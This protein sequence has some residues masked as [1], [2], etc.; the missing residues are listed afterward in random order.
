[1]YP[2]IIED[3]SFHYL[4]EN[5]LLQHLF[6]AGPLSSREEY[7]S[8]RAQWNENA[9]K[10]CSY[11]LRHKPELFRNNPVD[12][13]HQPGELLSELGFVTFDGITAPKYFLL[14]RAEQWTTLKLSPLGIRLA[15]LLFCNPPAYPQALILLLFVTEKL[16]FFVTRPGH[17]SPSFFAG[18]LGLDL[19]DTVRY[20]KWL[21]EKR[22]TN[23]EFSA[24]YYERE[25]PELTELGLSEAAR[26]LPRTDQ[27]L[28]K[29]ESKHVQADLT[30]HSNIEMI[31]NLLLTA[32]VMGLGLAGFKLLNTT[33]AI[34]WFLFC[35]VAL[36][37]ILSVPKVPQMA[38]PDFITL[39]KIGASQIPFV[40]D[41]L[42][43]QL[44]MPQGPVP[45]AQKSSMTPHQE[46]KDK[47]P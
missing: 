30:K 38:S 5:Y 28:D 14:L 13:A 43:K 37:I 45:E 44:G 15:E 10:I 11:A 16:A 18:I 47:Q 21:E 17:N 41:L 46:K 19:T 3:W 25:L 23:H 12:S 34:L 7:D 24:N 35:L 20:F 4:G 9:N 31:M 39:Y 22:W 8:L 36:P 32:L 1:M 29:N 33:Q 2:P 42:L 6:E 27:S 40:G 26:L